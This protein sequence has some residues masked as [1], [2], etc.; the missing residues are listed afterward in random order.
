MKTS[1]ALISLLAIS[2]VFLFSQSNID[3]PELDI[4]E[5]YAEWKAQHG[6]SYSTT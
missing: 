6:V 5:K 4:A 3:L 1:F 2:A